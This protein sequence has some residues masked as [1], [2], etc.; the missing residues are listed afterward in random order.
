[1]HQS[2]IINHGRSRCSATW[3]L[4]DC[5]GILA[6]I[7]RVQV[8]VICM[9]WQLLIPPGSLS[10]SHSLCLLSSVCNTRLCPV[11]AATAAACAMQKCCSLL[12]SPRGNSKL[13]AINYPRHSADIIWAHAQLELCHMPY[14]STILPSPVSLLRFPCHISHIIISIRIIVWG[15][16]KASSNC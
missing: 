10:L 6:R 16:K 12:M 5:Q 1:M 15:R 11:A 13:P 7:T 4:R 9:P 3:Y 2:F 14:E 8:L